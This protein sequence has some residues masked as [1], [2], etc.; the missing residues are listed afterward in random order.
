MV[1]VEIEIRQKNAHYAEI[2]EILGAY[3]KSE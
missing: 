2:E 1:A 3:N